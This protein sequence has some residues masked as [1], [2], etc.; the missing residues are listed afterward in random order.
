MLIVNF[1]RFALLYRFKECIRLVGVKHLI[2]VHDG[3]EIFGIGEVNDV[4]G[5]AREHVDSLDV[6]AR[7]FPLQHFAFGIVQVPLL[8]EAVALDHNELL[9]L[10]VVPVLALGDAG[11]GDVDRDLTGIQGMHQLG[12]GAAVVHVHL[13]VK[14]RLFIR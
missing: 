14:C 8:D 5:I 2:T 1:S 6:V 4:V 12:E 10:G 3:N 9:E 7:D 11:L 13:E